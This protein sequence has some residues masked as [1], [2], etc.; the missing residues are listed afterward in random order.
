MGSE[1]NWYRQSILQRRNRDT[2]IENECANIKG[3]RGEEIN[4]ENRSDIYTL[5]IPLAPWEKSY[6]K[7][8]QRI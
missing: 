6:D 2:D 5:L 3:E 8:R 4:L 1:K 7:P